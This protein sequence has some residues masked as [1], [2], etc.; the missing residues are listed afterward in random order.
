MI[1]RAR[2]VRWVSL[3][4]LLGASLSYGVASAAPVSDRLFWDSFEGGQEALAGHPW[5]IDS[6]SRIEEGPAAD[7]RHFLRCGCGDPVR[8]SGARLMGV[9]VKPHTG[10]LARCKIRC[11]GPAHHTFGI[12]KPNGLDFLSCR[13]AYVGSSAW[14]ESSLPFRT[15]EQTEIGFYLSR[16]YGTGS[17][18]FDSI[19]LVEDDTVKIGDISPA[20]NPF[21]QVTSA[22]SARGYLV[23]QQ[24]WMDLVYPTYYPT[25]SE[26]VKGL[27]CRLSIGEYEP[28]ALSITATRALKNL[29]VILDSD[30]LGPAGQ[31]LPATDVKLGVVRSITRWLTNSAPLQPGQRYERRPL[32]IFP[33]APVELPSKETQRF[34]VTVHAPSKAKPGSYRSS[35]TITAD[36]TTSVSLPLRVEVLPLRLP[37]PEATYGMFYRHG[38]Q[39]PEFRTEDYF[40]RCMIDMKAHG[41]NSVSVYASVERRLPDGSIA[42]SFDHSGMNNSSGLCFSLLRQMELLRESGLLTAGR[43]LPFLATG[44][45]GDGTFYNEEK[46]VAAAETLRK[47]QNWPEFLFYLV[48]EPSPERYD[49]VKELSDVVH[50]VPGVRTTTA[51]GEPGKLARFYDVWIVSESVDPIEPVVRHA[52]RMGKEAWTYE[53]QSNGAEPRNDR[54][55]TG[56][57][58]WTAKLK[59]N[60]QWC[61][62]EVSGG[63]LTDKGEIE[64][65]AAGYE[66]PWRNCYVLPGPQENIPTLGWE[67]RRE[68]IDDYR[69]LQALREATVAARHS[70]DRNRVRVAQQATRFLLSVE[71]RTKRPR[72]VFPST[73]TARVYNHLTHP[74]L[75]PSDYD[76]I[77][78]QAIDYL[79][80]LG[81]KGNW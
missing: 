23:S 76:A 47:T 41:C 60:C 30:L 50:R 7:G 42:I 64:L 65:S 78:G 5:Q 75:R 3:F 71:R 46:L 69:Y 53:C 39:F 34:W 79:M 49:Q 10:Y 72:Q 17:V 14:N 55:F 28:V 6:V 27:V 9:K 52:A 66:D 18:L 11:D 8:L 73:Q 43:P 40:K 81:G 22:E 59:G 77:R 68:G 13:D 21:P 19:E 1:L 37:E 38:E 67:A 31:R 35:L 74:G 63:R 33:N 4:G 58:T 51:I 45:P 16:R 57:F 80:R 32:F 61:Y 62:T 29:R 25:R 2:S 44:I 15:E 12:L 36:A 26:V 70:S 56:Y 24:H 20:P 54:Y 48:D